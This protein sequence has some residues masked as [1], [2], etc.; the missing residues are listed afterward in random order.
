MRVV[1]ALIAGLAAGTL[2]TAMLID[3]LRE[4]SA[5]PDGVMA[6]MS[7]QIGRINRQIE[8]QACRREDLAAPFATLAALGHDL[9]SAF[10]PTADD[11]RFS[12]LAGN[13]RAATERALIATLE[14]CEQAEA[15]LDAVRATC[16]DCHA[17]FRS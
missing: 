1:V 5:Y 6:V 11:L 13:Y 12:T 14:N 9:E 8:A 15:T 10:L 16:Q 2:A 4:R 3:H 7:A 17:E